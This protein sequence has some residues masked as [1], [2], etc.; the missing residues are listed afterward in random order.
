MKKSTKE[1]AGS[2]PRGSRPSRVASLQ[3]A[4]RHGRSRAQDVIAQR[5]RRAPRERS[6]GANGLLIAEGDSWFDYPFYDVLEKLEDDFNYRVESVAHKGDT[7]EEMAYDNSQLSK[8]AG[9][10]ERLGQ[11][12]QVPRAV[13]LSG[14]GNDVAGDEF[15]VFL[16]HK[17]SGLP[18]LNDA[19]VT[20]ILEGRLQFAIVSLISAMTEL[21]KKYFGRV[22]PVVTHGY[23]YPVPDGRGYLGGFWV[24]PGPWLEPGFRQKGYADMQERCD[25]MVALIDRFNG[26]LANLARQPGLSHVT[27]VDLRAILSNDLGQKRYRKF[28]ENELHPTESGFELVAQKLHEAIGKLP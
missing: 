24:L 10:F 4:I 3:A 12:G 22:V 5:R 19:V 1:A 26:L 28:W 14:G 15:A 8:L 13:L 18:P 23:G 7:V 25:V 9:R 17:S 2:R 16:N 21:S 6:T 11:Q 20:G 27:H